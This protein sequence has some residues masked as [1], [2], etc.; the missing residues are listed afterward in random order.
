MRRA[1]RLAAALLLLAARQAAAQ[2]LATLDCCWRLGAAGEAPRLEVELMVQRASLG[3]LSEGGGLR[4]GWRARAW[5]ERGGQVVAD[6]AW[7][8]EDWR[9]TG[10]EVGAAEKVPDQVLLEL[11]A[12]GEGGRLRLRL[13]DLAGGGSA[14]KS[15][16]LPAPPAGALGGLLLGVAPPEPAA[17]GP[18]RRGGWRFLPY[19]DALYGAGLDT[20]RGLVELRSAAPDSLELGLVVLGEGG[21]RLLSSLPRA[22]AAFPTLEGDPLQVAFALCVGTLP[23]GSYQLELE[24]LAGGRR[25]DVLLKPF[26]MHNPGVAAP[27]RP[28]SADDFASASPE[29]LERQW[30][31]AQA[32]ASHH[33]LQAWDRLD[34]E[35]RRA[36]L[37]EFW[38]R[39]DPDPTTLVNE[40]QVALL[41]R[42][43]EARARYGEPGRADLLSD[44]GRVFLRH[45]PPD[46]VETDY[47]S[48]AA[49]FDL[50]GGAG[51]E[52]GT[53]A[54]HRDFE[55]WIYNRL[56]GG[57]TFVFIDVKGFGTF[58]LVHS[59]KS[60]EFYDPNWTRKLFP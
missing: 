15:L 42:L 50:R 51:D 34:L 60:G 37:R 55:L 38:L 40:E 13:E 49:R 11:P 25:R 56:E 17:E 44:R 8:R 2:P 20:L 18:F 19:A 24:L 43:E 22:L 53:G 57:A 32:L 36:F 48:L 12:P 7:T 3:W 23:S 27:E 10:V 47:G 58:E 31:A 30:Q 41:S 1:E 5:V 39:R 4:G 21:S 52:G 26:W 59:T 45:G 6:T 9:A 29:E 35:G 46:A 54:G 33:E 16:R 28:L 14:E